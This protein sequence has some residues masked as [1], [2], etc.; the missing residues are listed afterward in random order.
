M[1]FRQDSSLT[2]YL[3]EVREILS[4]RAYQQQH[5]IAISSYVYLTLVTDGTLVV[6]GGGNDNLFGAT[7]K[8]RQSPGIFGDACTI[9]INTKLALRTG[10]LQNFYLFIEQ[11]NPTDPSSSFLWLQIWRRSG[12]VD[13]Y[14]LRWQR[15]VYL[16]DSSPQALYA[17]NICQR[18]YVVVTPILP[19]STLTLLAIN[20]S[21]NVIL[22]SYYLHYK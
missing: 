1:H 3:N 14:Q 10:L 13:Q 2:L 8:L 15:L 11:K 16:N 9:R 19:I 12:R 18:I 4:R 6:S 17:V 20:V 5:A 21:D 22:I 7:V